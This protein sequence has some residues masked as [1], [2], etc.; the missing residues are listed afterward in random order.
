MAN[1]L[2]TADTVMYDGVSMDRAYSG[3]TLIWCKTCPVV[4]VGFEKVNQG[5]DIVKGQDYV[6]RDERGYHYLNATGG[7]SS[8]FSGARVFHADDNYPPV[9][10][11]LC[12]GYVTDTGMAFGLHMGGTA[13]R[14]D[15][16]FYFGEKKSLATAVQKDL[17]TPQITYWKYG[18][19]MH[20]SY[21]FVHYNSGG[22]EEV[23]FKKGPIKISNTIYTP[24]FLY[25]VVYGYQT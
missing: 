2:W 21:I 17:S 1:T 8:S 25:R 6:F 9:Y 13:N 5:V 16:S 20:S 19:V 10:E 3:S 7:T 4:V 11:D 14:L 22:R 18:L 12:E 23:G 24:L 15:Y